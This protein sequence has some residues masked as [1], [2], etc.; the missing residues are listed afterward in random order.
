VTTTQEALTPVSGATQAR[1]PVPPH[2]ASGRLNSALTWRSVARRYVSALLDRFAA[3]CRDFFGPVELTLGWWCGICDDVHE[4]DAKCPRA[5]LGHCAD[6]KR[7]RAL[8]RW[9]N[10]AVCSSTS[11]TERRLMW[12]RERN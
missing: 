11:I 8:D 5:L 4:M 12:P 10:C 6:C 3:W 1:V 9:G 7:L 2:R